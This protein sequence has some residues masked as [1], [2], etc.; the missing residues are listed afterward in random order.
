[1]ATDTNSNDVR[2]NR[3]RRLWFRRLVALCGGA[4]V[5]AM[6]V[7]VVGNWIVMPLATRGSVMRVPDLYGL[8]VAVAKR[9]LLDSGLVFVNDSTDYLWDEDIPANHVVVQSPASYSLVKAGRRVRVTIS[10][11]PQLYPVPNVLNSSPVQAKLVLRQHQFAVG[12]VA[13]VLRTDADRSDPFILEQSPIAGIRLPR[14]RRVDVTVSLVPNMPDLSGR[15]YEE[16]KYYI[17]LLGLEVGSVTSEQS[18]DLLPWSVIRQS[19]PPGA[20]VR[21]GDRVNLVLSH[22]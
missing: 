4:F 8:D 22:L 18:A 1:M 11:G 21:V 9:A 2:D 19:T 17:E 10:R 15:S 6:F 3:P 5:A 7:F 14:G 12:K 20:R 13:F 16:A